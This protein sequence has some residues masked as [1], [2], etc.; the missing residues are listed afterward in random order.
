V[1]DLDQFRAVYE[2]AGVYDQRLLRHYYDGIEDIDLVLQLLERHY[3]RPEADLMIVEFGCGTGRI[4][5]RLIPYARQLI[6]ADYSQT[7]IDAVRTRLPQAETLCADT[8]DAI[9]HLSGNG[10]DG[11]F[12]VVAA[13]WSLSYPLGEFFETMTADGVSPTRDLAHARDQAAAFV[14]HLIDLLAP[15]GHLLALFFDAQTLEQRLVTRQWERI[16]LFPEGGRS[17]TLTLLLDGLRRAEQDER[18]TLTH[19]RQ[20]GTAW[21]PD[22][23]AAL[24]WF[25]IVHLKSFPALVN[26]PQVQHEVA[27]FVDRYARPAGDVALPSGV[28][29]IDFHVAG[30]P[31]CHLPDRRR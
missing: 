22:R 8:R 16:A 1:N 6:A 23:D 19:I 11:T 27:R 4:T 10:L 12:D 5:E 24:A 31:A 9:A 3:G 18:G 7:M 17:Y 30:H 20:G 2:T 14:R 13:F 29:V 15:G 28:H 21:A 26:D 25:N